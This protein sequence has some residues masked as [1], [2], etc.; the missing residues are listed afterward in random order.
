MRNKSPLIIVIFLLAFL[1]F[2]QGCVTDKDTLKIERSLTQNE[3]AYYNDSF[4]KL[5]DDLWERAGY[6]YSEVQRANFKLAYVCIENGKVRVETKTGCFSKGGLASKYALRGDFDIQMDCHIDFLKGR[7]DMDQ[8]L[9][10]KV[11][12]KV[13]EIQETESITIGLIRKGDHNFSAIFSGYAEKRKY[14]PGSWHKIG[15]FHGTLRI[16]RIGTRISTLYKKEGKTGWKK[17]NTFRFSANDIIFGFG[18]SNYESKRNTIKAR[19]PITATFDNF[20]INDAQEII[21]SEI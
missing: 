18:L 8:Y 1:V 21:E 9:A 2:F 16:R 15:N 7:Y 13:R 12:G 14:H 11:I 6:V 10:F 19:S 4:D 20:R 17:M 5:R 3:F